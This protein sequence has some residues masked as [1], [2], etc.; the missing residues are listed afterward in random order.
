MVIEV[1]DENY[2][3]KRV[4][5]HLFVTVERNIFTPFIASDSVTIYDYHDPN[6]MIHQMVGQDGDGVSSVLCL[7]S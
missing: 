2:P 6:E 4:R 5:T 1:Y 7:H 3:T